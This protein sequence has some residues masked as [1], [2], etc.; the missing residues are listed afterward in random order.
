MGISKTMYFTILAHWFMNKI[1][2]FSK[3]YKNGGQQ[4]TMVANTIRSTPS[5]TYPLNHTL[6]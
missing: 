2:I 3:E 6:I 1:C 5:L 4:E